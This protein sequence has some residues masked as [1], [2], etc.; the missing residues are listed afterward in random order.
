VLNPAV[1]TRVVWINDWFN[2]PRETEAAQS[3]INAGADVLMET[4]DSP[5]VLQVAERN[6]KHGFG[7]ASDM[8]RFGG[9]AHL[10]SVV[11]N[12]APYY[13]K[14]VRDVLDGRWATGQSWWGIKEGAVD[15][16]GVPDTLPAALRARVDVARSGLRDGSLAIWTGPLQDN[17]GRSVL[18]PGQTGDD[19]FL[20]RMQFYVKGVEGQVPS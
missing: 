2:P 10:G 1:R 18:V 17:G 12:W 15:L 5:A 7:L 14:A 6:G 11:N 13:A 8:S 20:R 3:L 16:A 19:A 9:R 4:T